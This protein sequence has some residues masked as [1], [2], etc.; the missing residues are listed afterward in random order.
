MDGRGHLLVLTFSDDF[1]LLSFGLAP[2]FNY[3]SLIF[4]LSSMLELQI[5]YVFDGRGRKLCRPVIVRIHAKKCLEIGQKTGRIRLTKLLFVFGSCLYLGQLRGV[6]GFLFQH[7]QFESVQLKL[8]STRILFH[9]PRLIRSL[10]LKIFKLLPDGSFN[11]L[12]ASN[13]NLQIC[14]LSFL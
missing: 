8:D 2:R 11:R 9:L 10:L 7:V 1:L 12:K 4:Y 6:L 13:L 5:L 3:F 14:N